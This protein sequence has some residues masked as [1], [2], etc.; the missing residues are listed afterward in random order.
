M[1]KY[2][3]S[4]VVP[5]FQIGDRVKIRYFGDRIGRIAELSGPIGPG[6][7]EVY[8]VVIGRGARPEYIMLTGDQMDA[9]TRMDDSV[10]VIESPV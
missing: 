2:L 10:P 5:A 6:G 3:A 1:D 9:A 4:H 7:K 8:R